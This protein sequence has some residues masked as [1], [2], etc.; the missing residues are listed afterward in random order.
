MTIPY[1]KAYCD[2]MIAYFSEMRRGENN[3]IVGAPSFLSFAKEIGVPITQLEKWRREHR[4]F[5]EAADHAVEILKEL[6]IDA[7]LAGIVNV[8][9]AKFILSS[10]FGMMPSEKGGRKQEGEGLTPDDRRLLQN[11]EERLSREEKT[12]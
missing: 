1:R 5:D 6:L 9:A 8:S 10:E 11:L 12:S 7:A 2:K 4:D 3:E